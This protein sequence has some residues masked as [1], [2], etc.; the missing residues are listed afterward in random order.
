MDSE[1]P[2]EPVEID[3][4]SQ[5]VEPILVASYDE[6]EQQPEVPAQAP[7]EVSHQLPAQFQ[8]VAA[9]GGAVGSI[10]LGCLTIFGV[11]VT[12][13]SLFNA[14]V[15]LLLGLWGLKSTLFRTA[16]AGICFCLIG[17]VLCFAMYAK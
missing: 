3:D 9:K 14:I 13:W 10:V 4:S 12:Q 8:N 1:S 11:F 7:L 6:T 15:G 17:L 2:I 5:A 16:V